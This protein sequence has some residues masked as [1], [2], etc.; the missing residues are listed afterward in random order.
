MKKRVLSAV[1]IT[2]LAN[3]LLLARPASAKP[4]ADKQARHGEKVKA[5][6]AKLGSG[7]AAL[8]EVHLRDKTRLAGHVSQINEDSFAVI[9]SKTGQAATVAYTSVR[10]IKGHNLSTGAKIAIGVGIAVAALLVLA[11]IGLHYAD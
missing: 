6:V 5:A 7:K 9:Q 10:Q 2:L 4:A 1:I 11:L 8:V 3:T